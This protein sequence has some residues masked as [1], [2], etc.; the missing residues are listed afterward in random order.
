[1]IV[2]QIKK[3]LRNQTDFIAQS[4]VRTGTKISDER[5][6]I[7][8]EIMTEFAEYIEVRQLRLENEEIKLD[9]SKG[10][11]IDTNIPW[12]RF[13]NSKTPNPRSGW[14]LNLFVHEDGSGCSLAISLGVYDDTNTDE[15]A[16]L[17]EKILSD[18]NIPSSLRKRPQV[19]NTKLGR[20]YKD[21]SAVST[22]W[23]GDAFEELSEEDFLQAFEEFIGLLEYV[24]QTYPRHPESRYWL[25]QYNPEI[26]D[27][28]R[29]ASDGVTEFSFKIGNYKDK[30]QVGDLVLIWRSGSDA[31]V[32][33]LGS[34]SRSAE[35]G[36]PDEVTARYY[37]DETR[38][39]I[40]SARIVIKINKVFNPYLPKQ[41]LRE[42]LKSN[43]I[44]KNPQSSSPF[45]VHKSEFDQVISFGDSGMPDK[46][47]NT[48]SLAEE[49]LIDEKWLEMLKLELLSKRQLILQGP[50]GT[51]KT[52]IAQAIAR[53]LAERYAIVQFHPSY[54]YEDFVEGFRPVNT[55]HGLAFE[56]KPGPLVHLAIEAASN[57]D[58]K[59][60]LVIDEI[61]RGNLA[62]IFGELYFL[63]EYRNHDINMQYR[64]L[65]S[66]FSLPDNLL[67]L[68][69][70]NTADRSIAPLDMAI[71]RRFSFIE[72]NP[73]IEPIKGLLLRWLQREGLPPHLDDVLNA[74]NLAINDKR[75]QL[76]PSYFMKQDI[77]ENIEQ[78]WNFQVYPQLREV[79][80]DNQEL[81]ENF[82]FDSIR[83]QLPS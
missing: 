35:D 40:V 12:I 64:D 83:H 61:N 75:F 31:G 58:K 37:L 42:I 41:S 9:R 48:N 2:S 15:T 51:G 54:A 80:F 45:V 56:I 69:T 44:I 27:F 72:L 73:Q 30:V 59:F 18:S 50:P 39:D 62:K 16:E 79:F 8:Q 52:F 21:G 28:E 66:T 20:G 68:G 65:S 46:E 4:P 34:V 81:L 17:T 36:T 77:Y 55:E 5:K 38:T 13:H 53:T 71:R 25:I 10:I 57:P 74:I 7:M 78:V 22:E 29:L 76:G 6:E 60:I 26:W 23:T 32:V 47:R 1:M 3:W 70:M 19:G 82:T 49:L 67:I 24:L 63:L 11:G 14:S 43:L 33:G